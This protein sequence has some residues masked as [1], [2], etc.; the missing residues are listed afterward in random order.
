MEEKK[1]KKVGIYGL[2]CKETGKWYVGQ[3]ID[4]DDR[5]SDYRNVRCHGQ[6]LLFNA[7]K[8]HSPNG[9]EYFI[10]QEC[11]PEELDVMET[12]WIEKKNSLAPHGYNLTTGGG[13]K[14]YSQT[15]REKMS[16]SQT[17]KILSEETRKKMSKS[18]TGPLNHF[19]GKTH[20]P[21]VR[22]RLS[23]M[24]K[25]V[26]SKKRGTK[27]SDEIKKKIS[28]TLKGRKLPLETRQKMSASS[29]WK[30]VKPF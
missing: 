3:S 21:E 7:L 26:P 9:F 20:T 12:I 15:S 18:R 17:G 2:L 29:R 28:D 13:R 11:T 19:F 4:I 8:K 23:E 6:V 10:V 1:S 25:S 16:K 5:W 30:K 22:K 14:I 24:K 27:L